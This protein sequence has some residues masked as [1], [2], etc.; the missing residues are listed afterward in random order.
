MN[1]RGSPIESSSSGDEVSRYA[2]LLQHPHWTLPILLRIQLARTFILQKLQLIECVFRSV[3]FNQYLRV[4]TTTDRGWDVGGQTVIID[5]QIRR[6]FFQTWRLGLWVLFVV[7]GIALMGS[8]PAGAVPSFSQQ[9]GQPCSACHIGAFGPQLKT[10]GR[11]F[12][13]YGYQSGDG[14]NHLPPVTLMAQTS[15]THTSADQNPPP[16][17]NFGQNDNFAVDQVSLFF[18]GKAPLGFGVFAQITYDS[19]GRSFSLDNVDIRRVKD[20]TLFGQDAVVGLDFN[21]NPTVQDVWNS[22]PAW[23]FPYNASALAPG[24]VAATLI[25]GGLAGTVAG[26]GV[27]SVWNDTIYLEATAYA[28]LERRLAGRLGEGVGSTS[29]RYDGLV[30]YWRVALLHD[31]GAVTTVEVGAYGIRAERYPGGDGSAGTD[32]LN[33][34]AIDGNFQYLVSPKQI[35]SAHATYIHEDQDLRASTV[36]AGTRPKNQLS[37]ARADISYSYDDT[38]TPSVQVFQTTGTSDP[39]LYGPGLRTSGHVM[40]LAWTPYGRPDSKIYWANVRFGLQYVGYTE[41]N[42]VSRHAGDNNM[43]YLNAWIALA[44]LAWAVQR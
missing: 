35:V 11:D 29:D 15:V 25:D 20:L 1:S 37:T 3:E 28:P 38:W 34:W 19:V 41:F 18:A 23:G 40:E 5:N 33:D 39:V 4:C 8:T 2:P 9:T 22:T 16:A 21:N 13:L 26:A 32:V 14:K 31:Y 7:A 30:P 10:Y 12:K 36:L 43:L 17:P 42:G 44:P 6:N 27:Y 24:Q